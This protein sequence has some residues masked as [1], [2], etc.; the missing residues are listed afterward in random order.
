MAVSDEGKNDLRRRRLHA[1]LEDE[2]VDLFPSV[3]G[4]TVDDAV[5]HAVLDEV[6]HARYVP[7]HEGLR[8]TYGVV[9]VDEFPATQPSGTQAPAH[10][11][12][13]AT[14]PHAV[15]TVMTG[16]EVRPVSTSSGLAD[17]RPLVDGISTV[18]TRNLHGVASIA[19]V[20]WKDELDVLRVVQSGAIAVVQRMPDGV[21][22]VVTEGVV[23]VNE[24][25]DW[26]TREPARRLVP[27]LQKLF[28]LPA[29]RARE[30]LHGLAELLD[31][32]V[33]SLS[34]RRIGAT[35]VVDLGTIPTNMTTGFAGDTG[36]PPAIDLNVFNPIDQPLI[37][38][39]L[40]G[41]DGAC[42]ITADGQMTSHR[43]TLKPSDRAVGVV[44][45][46]GGTRHTSAKRFSFDWANCI[47]VTVSADGPVTVFSDGVALISVADAVDMPWNLRL[48]LT[49]QA[50]VVTDTS[51][52][53]CP[54]CG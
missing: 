28:D 9:V 27:D 5:R 34:P 40:S 7:V 18:V 25:F 47:V 45:E 1:E 26:R 51:D 3:D 6:V 4:K 35:F 15:T 54:T 50:G 31:L 52:Q 19:A 14:H 53:G 46:H 43:V 24:G 36:V 39:L 2:G 20:S 44:R 13:A 12:N 21:V 32:C 37:A 29:A 22:R 8:P 23:A 33:H 41:V 49:D 11:L 42:L 10:M 30:V 17:L 38:N 48:S 16:V